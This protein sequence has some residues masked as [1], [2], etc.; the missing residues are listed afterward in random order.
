MTKAKPRVVVD[1][2]MKVAWE[3]QLARLKQAKQEETSG[4]DELYEAFGAILKSEPPLY[5]A[6]GF[7]SARDFLRHEL[8]GEH[9]RTIYSH[10]RVAESFDPEDEARYGISKLEKLLDYFA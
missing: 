2:A 3:I 7:R 8:P 9:E 5:L 6:G 4:W 1:R 10:I